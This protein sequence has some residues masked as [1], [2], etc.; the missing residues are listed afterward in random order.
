MRNL[1]LSLFFFL[2]SFLLSQNSDSLNHFDGKIWTY[3][4][5]KSV[6]TEKQYALL[7]ENGIELH[8]Y[9]P[10]LIWLASFPPTTSPEILAEAGVKKTGNKP[11]E[12]KID[13]QLLNDE[14]PEYAR[15]GNAFRAVLTVAAVQD[16]TIIKKALFQRGIQVNQLFEPLGLMEIEGSRKALI[17]AARLPFVIYIELPNPPEELEIEDEMTM[18]RAPYINGYYNLNGVNGDGV[19]IAVNE[20]GRVDSIYTI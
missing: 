1:F 18:T 4:T 15:T 14:I 3:F 7:K 5:F 10:D 12:E 6:P 16:Y 11:V 17:N 8:Q 19:T 9:Q 20:G 13:F 2:P